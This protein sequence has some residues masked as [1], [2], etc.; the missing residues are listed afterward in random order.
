MSEG[1]EPARR[2]SAPDSESGA[3]AR[4]VLEAIRS[5]RS[6]RRYKEEPVPDEVVRSV[7]D[8]ARTAPAAG[9]RDLRRFRAIRSRETLSRMREAVERKIASVRERIT[10][11]KAQ[12]GY[13]AYTSTFT[14]FAAAPVVVAVIARPYDSIYTRILDR[15]IAADEQPRQW[16]VEPASMSA[17]AAV[18][19]MLLAA[20]ALGYGGCFMTGPMIAQE[21]IESVLGVEE[22]WHV[23]ALVP[24]GRPEGSPRPGERIGLD[25]VLSFD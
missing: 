13:D 8:A 7:V 16:L 2:S 25:E 3:I 1:A 14:H 23:V 18:E 21:E 19:N 4:P 6:I 22:P 17:A 20:H 12:K 10:S 5:R 24:L 15:Y 9:A 11:P